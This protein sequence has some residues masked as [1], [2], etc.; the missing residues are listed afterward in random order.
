MSRVCPQCGGFDFTAGVELAVHWDGREDP[1]EFPVEELPSKI[2]CDLVVFLADTPVVCN[3]YECEWT[4]K[5]CEL[6][7]R[8][9]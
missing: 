6:V 4:G 9:E 8:K 3:N 5:I 2:R 7:Q 1:H